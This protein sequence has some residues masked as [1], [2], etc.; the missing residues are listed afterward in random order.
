MHNTKFTFA[1]LRASA[2]SLTCRQQLGEF[3]AYDYNVPTTASKLNDC[4]SSFSRSI[5]MRILNNN[6]NINVDTLAMDYV[7]FSS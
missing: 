7:I 2:S 6:V 1:E 4:I 3:L 5:H